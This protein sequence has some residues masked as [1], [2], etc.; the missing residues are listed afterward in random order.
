MN[1]VSPGHDITEMV[2]WALKIN[3]LPI[4]I[5]LVGAFL[6]I[7]KSTRSATGLKVLKP[8]AN[9]RYVMCKSLPY[10]FQLLYRSTFIVLSAKRML[11]LFV[12]S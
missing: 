11:D 8:A 10:S 4:I 6:K 7:S 12:F 9:G 3:Y 5:V 2:D 1:C